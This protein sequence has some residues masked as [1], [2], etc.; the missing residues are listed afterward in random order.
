MSYGGALDYKTAFLAARGG[1]RITEPDVILVGNGV[2]LLTKA[3]PRR[4]VRIRPNTTINN[5]IV[6]REV[7]T[8]LKFESI[9]LFFILKSVMAIFLLMIKFK[10]F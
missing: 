6:F 7:R 8:K 9:S 2:M 5:K 1:Q 3:E 10:R 4:E